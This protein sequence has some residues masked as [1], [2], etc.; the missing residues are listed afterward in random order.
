MNRRKL[1]EVLT[2]DEVIRLLSTPNKRYP[3]SFRN[4]CTMRLALETGLRISEMIHLQIEHIDWN[5]SKVFIKNGKG[6]K[7]RI[8]YVRNE[9]LDQL[10]LLRERFNL[11]NTGTLFT[12][13]K[14]D[15]LDTGY[16]RKMIKRV[17]AKAGITKRVYFH[18]LRHTFGSETYRDTKD[19]RT[20]QEILGHSDVSTTMLY[21]TISNEDVEKVMTRNL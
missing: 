19:I 17:A 3:T 21:S 6:D 18:L 15:T 4:Y 16:L 7:D 5:T 12:T 1:P 14:G 13:L 9:M 10:K 8:I 20:L 2:P 11:T